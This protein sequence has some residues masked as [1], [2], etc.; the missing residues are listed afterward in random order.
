M[1]LS[2]EYRDKLGQF[3]KNFLLCRRL[4]DS[5][6]FLRQFC[7]SACKSLQGSDLPSFRADGF[8][9]PHEAYKLFSLKTPGRFTENAL[10]NCRK[11]R[12]ISAKQRG[13]FTE[14]AQQSWQWLKPAFA[15]SVKRDFYF[16]EIFCQEK[17]MVV[18][19]LWLVVSM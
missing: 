6:A 7:V 1:L 11:C 12:A 10:R 15:F 16:A 17:V 13:V 4:R 19:C 14:N 5:R 9:R 18:R 2:R 8:C 3:F